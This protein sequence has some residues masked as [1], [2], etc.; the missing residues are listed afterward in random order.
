MMNLLYQQTEF[1]VLQNRMYDT[2]DEAIH[3]LKGDIRLIE[4]L[5][6]G[7]VFNADFKAELM[8]YD[9]HYQNEQAVSAIFQRHLDAVTG[10]IERTLGRK[11]LVELG[12]GKGFFLELLLA[13]G[14]DITGFDPAYEGSNPKVKRQY[15]THEMMCSSQG[16]ILRH[17]LEHIVNPVKF[18][19]QLKLANGGKGKVY[20]EVPCFD[21]ICEH[22]AWFD[23][24]YEH[25]NYFRLSDFKRIFGEVIDS[26]RLFGE[27]YFYVVAELSS[28][29]SPKIDMD[30]RVAFPDNFL[31]A[32]AENMPKQ[33]TTIWGGASKGVIFSLLLQKETGCP[34]TTVIDINPAKQGCFLP[35]TGLRVQSP[36]EAM[37]TLPEGSV[38]HVMNSNYID[39]IKAMSQNKY[40]YLGV[41][42]G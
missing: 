11:G 19:Q 6:T 40:V 18:L 33:G 39:E 4:D 38:I 13:K 10:L 30:D 41:D 26:G 37:A 36:Q 35:A 32:L 1:P 16:I 34:V 5:Q 22:K 15:F 42:N 24:F 3:C 27:Q 17:V 2:A 14:F 12:C 28:L 23:I 29:R 21:W 9:S 7:L 8:N 31:T 25:V 20:I